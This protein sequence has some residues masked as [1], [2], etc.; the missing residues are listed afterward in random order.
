MPSPAS[1]VSVV[2]KRRRYFVLQHVDNSITRRNIRHLL[3]PAIRC[4]QAALGTNPVSLAAPGKHGDSFVLDMATTAVAVGKVRLLPACHILQSSN[5]PDC[6]PSSSIQC[7][8]NR[9][10]NLHHRSP[11]AIR[12]S[13]LSCARCFTTPQYLD[14]KASSGKIVSTLGRRLTT[15][16]TYDHKKIN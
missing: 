12:Q 11:S 1:M 6:H 13:V 10:S 15:G 16:R 8:S 9:V 3:T 2:A 7:T 14:Y 4:W 5:P